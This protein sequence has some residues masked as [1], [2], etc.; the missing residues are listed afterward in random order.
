MEPPRDNEPE[1]VFLHEMASDPEG[2]TFAAII[3][4]ELGI[5]LKIEY[6]L[7]E[8][9]YFMQWKSVASGDYVVGLEPANSS[10]YGKP[11]HIKEN[12]LHRMEPMASEK[13][14][15]VLSFLTGRQLDEVKDEAKELLRDRV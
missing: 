12:N 13:K 15:I 9:P 14:R 4:K 1:D 7:K 6:N 8:L 10:V 11:Y 5:G 2:N 3:N